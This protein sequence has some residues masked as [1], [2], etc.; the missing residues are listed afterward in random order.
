M[1][2]VIIGDQEGY[3]YP[4]IF[5]DLWGHQ[6]VVVKLIQPGQTVLSAGFV[7]SGADGRLICSGR[8]AGLGIASRNDRDSAVVSTWLS[9]P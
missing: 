1:K 3:E 9:Q 6:E 7:K 5:P 4:I 8:S 2:Y